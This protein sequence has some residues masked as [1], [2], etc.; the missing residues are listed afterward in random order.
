M[1]E[2]EIQNERGYQNKTKQKQMPSKLVRM[3]VSS[4]CME[5]HS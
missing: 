4:K 3:L 2:V 5:S 1:T